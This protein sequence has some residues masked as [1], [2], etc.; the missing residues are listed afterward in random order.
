MILDLGDLNMVQEGT[1]MKGYFAK[2]PIN[3][4]NFTGDVFTMFTCQVKHSTSNVFR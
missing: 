1:V 3:V 2:V 4:E